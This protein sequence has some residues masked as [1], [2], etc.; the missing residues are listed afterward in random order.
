MQSSNNA[1][2]RR[3]HD[4]IP[5]QLLSIPPRETN[6]CSSS[7]WPRFPSTCLLVPIHRWPQFNYNAREIICSLTTFSRWV[8]FLTLLKHHVTFMQVLITHM[9]ISIINMPD[10][11]MVMWG[12]R[13]HPDF[14]RLCHHLIL[15]DFPSLTHEIDHVILHS[16]E[17]SHTTIGHSTCPRPISPQFRSH[18]QRQL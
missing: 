16:L 5:M 3:R 14:S 10:S 7:L 9:Q 17:F 8:E 18:N 13:K 11:Q 12:K 2:R 4:M 6:E 15:S 1:A